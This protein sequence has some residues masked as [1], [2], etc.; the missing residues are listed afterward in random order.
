MTGLSV[1]IM[2]AQAQLN[3]RRA[4]TEESI[5]FLIDAKTSKLVT[6]ESILSAAD[7][8]AETYRTINA[9]RTGI[10]QLTEDFW[11]S[12]TGKL[13]GWAYKRVYGDNLITFADAIRILH[14]LPKGSSIENKLRVQITNNTT[15]LRDANG[16]PNLTL[17][18]DHDDANTYY[19]R[20][21]RS[22]VLALKE[23]K[24]SGTTRHRSAAEKNPDRRKAKAKA[25]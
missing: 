16:K 12:D 19:K 21:L 10:A 7:K 8:V 11:K 15:I 14:D 20:L 1:D 17:Y 22:E 9:S 6:N 23:R 2:L 25:V 5:A 24:A 13:L 4:A 18:W 3:N